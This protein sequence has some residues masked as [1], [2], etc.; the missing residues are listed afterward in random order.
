MIGWSLR[1]GRMGLAR[2]FR[3]IRRSG[4]FDAT[5]YLLRYPKAASAPGHPALH[6]VER[7][8]A[9][10]MNPNADFDTRAY[11][12]EH[13]ELAESGRNPFAHFLRTEAAG[14]GRAGPPE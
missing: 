9:E 6:Y 14:A 1:P 5:F 11:L 10:G 8:A 12:N 7:G 13:P 2:D 3:T 4:Q